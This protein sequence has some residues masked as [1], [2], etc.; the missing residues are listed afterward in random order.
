MINSE[1]YKF[2]QNLRDSNFISADNCRESLEKIKDMKYNYS[3]Y[4]IT[5]PV[6]YEEE[7]KRLPE[8]DYDLCCALFSM[9]LQ[10]RSFQ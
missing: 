3:D 6:N 8:A 1:K 10:R 2:L 5:E 7:L 4:L 9:V